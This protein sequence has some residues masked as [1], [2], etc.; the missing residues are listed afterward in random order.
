MLEAWLI[1]ELKRLEKE[2]K[3]KEQNNNRL[4]IEEIEYEQEEKEKNIEQ[5]PTQSFCFA[6]QDAQWF[7]SNEK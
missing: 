2:K 5:N 6:G 1:E 3:E 4:Y 7:G